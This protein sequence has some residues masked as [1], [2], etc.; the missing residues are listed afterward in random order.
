MRRSEGVSVSDQ[1]AREKQDGNVLKRRPEA[2]VEALV[3]LADAVLNCRCAITTLGVTNDGSE[4]L[5][6]LRNRQ[7]K[8]LSKDFQSGQ[9]HVLFPSLHI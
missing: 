3:Q 1:K 4:A 9:T 6:Q 7:S 8:G 5:Q 2:L